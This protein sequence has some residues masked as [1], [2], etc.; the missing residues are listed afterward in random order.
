L[1]LVVLVHNSASVAQTAASSAGVRVACLEAAHA[2]IQAAPKQLHSQ[3]LS[4]NHG[5]LE[6]ITLEACAQ[7]GVDGTPHA[8]NHL[9]QRQQ[10]QQQQQ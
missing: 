5:Q 8:L 2:V 1:H 7:V 4:F 3:T 10:Q 6:G 9:Q